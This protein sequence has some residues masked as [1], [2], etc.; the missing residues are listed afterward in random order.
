MAA[1]DLL[2]LHRPFFLLLLLLLFS[3]RAS[4][5]GVNYG[6][7]GNNL[8]PPN[9]VANFLK[10]KTTI[11]RVKIFDANPDILRGFANSGIALTIT[12]ANGDIPALVNLPAA[13]SW[14]NSN[15]KP[16][17]PATNIN[18]ILVGN[19]I[20]HSLDQHLID[21]L[22]PAMKTLHLALVLAGISRIQV[23][24]AH[25]LG[26]LLKS[27][28]PS[29]GR[30]RPGWDTGVLKPMLDFHRQTKSAFVVNPY[31]YFSY[32]PKTVNYAQF[33]RNR[34]YRDRVTGLT[35]FN[36]FDQ[37]MDAVYSSMKALGYADVPICVGETGWPSVANPGQV[38]VS[39]QDAAAYNGNLLRHVS[40]KKG[41]PLMPNRR[42][43]TYI[44][45]LFN[46][47]QKPGPPAEQ[48]FGLFQPDFTPVYDIGIMRQAGG[49]PGRPGGGGGGG[50]P[51]PG[52]GKKW[53]V[54]RGDATDA[55]LQKNIDYVCSLGVDCK[56]IQAGGACYQPN[57][58]KAHAGFVM[59]SYYQT[60][61]R[62]DF[63]CDFAHTGVVTAVDPSTGGCRYA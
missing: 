23:S 26:I 5:I 30:F 14:V 13:Q 27:Q 10:T 16:F 48:N 62:Q 49:G 54:P 9:V 18:R 43:E 55:A 53:C 24:T 17:Y 7:L 25:S 52:G 19:E 46:E 41:T 57:N 11:D 37:L 29:M 32:G 45:A 21:N 15:V 56:P 42:F 40:S 3:A 4:A 6:T 31:P 44:F 63:N 28:P 50:S 1:T 39:V 36:M 38:G 34:G 20:L 12:V 2:H 60:H 58:I 35:Y 22:V 51:R 33:K 59:N 61:G 47:N 8:P